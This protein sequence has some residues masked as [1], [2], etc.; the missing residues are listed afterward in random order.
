MAQESKFG[1]G[2]SKELRPVTR[3]AGYQPPVEE[4]EEEEDDD[5]KVY[6]PEE[7]LPPHRVRLLFQNPIEFRVY[8]WFI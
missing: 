4:E 6:K 2:G 1:S 7:K 8:V 5:E 3:E